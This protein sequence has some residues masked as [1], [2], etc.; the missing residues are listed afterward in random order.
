M[1]TRDREQRWHWPLT[2]AALVGVRDERL[3]QRERRRCRRGVPAGGRPL[4]IR[5]RHGS[6]PV[7]IGTIAMAGDTVTL[8]TG[9]SVVVKLATGDSSQFKGR[10]PSPC[11]A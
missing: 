8:P 7:K 1:K 11:R 9:G 6:V 5:A 4:H 3:G 10:A 2:V